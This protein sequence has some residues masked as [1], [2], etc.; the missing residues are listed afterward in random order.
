MK[1]WM[2]GVVVIIAILLALLASTVDPMC[3]HK[4]VETCGRG[5]KI[6]VLVY[7]IGGY[8][9]IKFAKQEK[10]VCDIDA[11][12]YTTKDSVSNTDL[13]SLRAQG[14]RIIFTTRANAT[15][16]NSSDRLTSKRL[17]WN[18]SSEFKEYD[19]V[20]THDCN[21]YIDY[22][23][24]RDFITSEMNGYSV[25][26]KNWN[27]N[28]G[29]WKSGYRIFW[30]I[31][32]FL[33]SRIDRIRESEEE[34]KKWRDMLRND[35]TY[36]PEPYFETNVFIFSPKCVKYQIFGRKVYE[37]CHK[38]QRD[39]F[40]V[41]YVLFQENVPFKVKSQQELVEKIGYKKMSRHL[42]NEKQQR[43]RHRTA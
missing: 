4:A 32:D 5:H 43:T 14:W 36:N 31:N 41:P 29:R 6:A 3:G 19:Y 20:L 39:Q 16:N 24:V 12:F 2:L 23:K 11:F 38:L 28:D 7:N 26:F 35:N 17:K 9:T 30:E 15:A 21:L 10:V 8:D 33:T 27:N 1:T 25:L 18:L 13:K 22:A 42:I 37:H 34:T 40:I